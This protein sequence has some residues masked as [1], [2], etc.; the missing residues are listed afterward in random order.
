[1]S[2]ENA[3][4]DD[5]TQ[6]QDIRPLPIT[7]TP[8]RR[9]GTAEEF[10]G[11]IVGQR[12]E[13][14]SVLGIG[15]M[16][17]VFSVRDLQTN[18]ELALKLLRRSS[19][20]KENLHRFRREVAAAARVAHPHL[21]QVFAQGVHRGAPFLVMERLFGETLQ[22]RLVRSGA[23]PIVDCVVITLQLL[24]ALSAVHA[25]GYLHRDVKPS[26]VFLCTSDTQSPDIRLIDFGLAR[27]L[28]RSPLLG[29]LGAVEETAL[30]ATGVIPGT[31]AY[32]APEQVNGQ[33]DLDE[34]VDVWA[35]GLTL[36]EML[37]GHRVF[38]GRIFGDIANEIV[39][40]EVPP[41]SS[42]QAHLPRDFDHLLARALAR[43]REQRFATAAAF[44]RSL[45]DVW[46]RYRT[47][48]IPTR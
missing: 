26:N 5:S 35:V 32:L 22:S 36:H 14:V 3:D 41:P 25:A 42:R 29:S 12:Y 34:R 7:A 44:R 48:Q 17:A 4:T 31:P 2:T 21:C 46:A 47:S 45:V 11:D 8:R 16:G 23:L 27:A 18:A 20:S 6:S 40:R 39:S 37:C 15:G 33:R 9:R 10:V 1:M 24:D 43:R 28:R 30:T 19:F 13:I 38:S